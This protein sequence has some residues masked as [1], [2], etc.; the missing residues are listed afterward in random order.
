VRLVRMKRA[1][2][3]LA[4]GCLL[5]TLAKL[6]PNATTSV[7][8]SVRLSLYQEDFRILDTMKMGPDRLFRNVGTKLPL[9]AA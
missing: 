2:A 9:L 5:G 1:L 7:L 8:L 3:V 6:L 4:F